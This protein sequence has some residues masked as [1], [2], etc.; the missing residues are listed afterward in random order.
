VHTSGLVPFRVLPPQLRIALLPCARSRSRIVIG[1]GIAWLTSRPGLPNVPTY[2]LLRDRSLLVG[3]RDIEPAELPATLTHRV[4][5]GW[6]L[7]E[8]TDAFVA[9]ASLGLWDELFRASNALCCSHV[10][11]SCDADLPTLLDRAEVPVAWRGDATTVLDELH[12]LDLLYRFPV[13][14]RF[15]DVYGPE[16]QYRLSGW[17]RRLFQELAEQ[18]PYSTP[19][20]RW[21]ESLHTHIREHL[22]SYRAHMRVLEGG[23]ARDGWESSTQLP[24]GV[25]L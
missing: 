12:A 14:H 10:Y 17:G 24:I 3:V 16:E 4:E 2:L 21:Q 8:G 11:L 15:R 18:E 1:S 25:L 22:G 7:K 9:L 23:D 13:A 6:L 5:D 19:I 20:G